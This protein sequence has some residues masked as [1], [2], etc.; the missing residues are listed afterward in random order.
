MKIQDKIKLKKKVMILG[1]SYNT[2]KDAP[3]DNEDYTVIALSAFQTKRVDLYFEMHDKKVWRKGT[4]D[5]LYSCNKPVICQKQYGDL[6]KSI[7]F[8]FVECFD[9]ISLNYYTSSIAYILA[10]IFLYN[11]VEEVSLYGIDLTDDE[12]Y[13]N[14]RP[15]A[16]YL[17]GLLQ[18]KG[19]KIV[20]PDKSAL[21][22]SSFLY[23]YQ[24]KQEQF[25]NLKYFEDRQR[26]LLQER[27]EVQAYIKQLEGSI[28]ENE[29]HIANYKK[30]ERGGS[31]LE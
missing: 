11:E 2:L 14:Q 8:P 1:S 5:Y 22:K 16:E 18:G 27:K 15:C 23:G 28:K 30:I 6:P 12:E 10:F 19:I 20:I 31:F 29:Q 3:L 9:A 21:L 17:L 26:K 24:Q 13:Q 4:N 7:E 25:L